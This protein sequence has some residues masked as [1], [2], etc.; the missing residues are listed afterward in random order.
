MNRVV[1]KL[2]GEAL[3]GPSAPGNAPVPFSDAVI[4]GIARQIKTVLDNN[5][6]VALVV[7]GGNFWRGKKAKAD[8]DRSRSDQIGM[9]GTVMNGIY[10]SEQFKKSGV[11]SVVMTPFYLS[12]FSQ[13]FEKSAALKYMAGGVVVINSG[14]TGHPYFSTD[15][16]AALRAA[17]L[18]ADMVVYA[19][20]VDGVYDKDPGRHADARK[21]RAVT[22]RRVIAE[23]L[24]AAD[25][26]GMAISM[27]QGMDSFVFGLNAHDGVVK[28]CLGGSGRDLGTKVAVDIKEDFYV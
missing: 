3:A 27:E 20:N 11:E 25:I 19:K 12:F 9:L 23:R 1:I 8:M 28:A 14:G 26:A 16:V 17:E 18:E 22:Y 4:D 24:D 21:F 10:L 7:G 6:Q 15:T 2:S 5:V 13:L